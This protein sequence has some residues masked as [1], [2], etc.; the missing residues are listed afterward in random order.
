MDTISTKGSGSREAALEV[1]ERAIA[2]N[3]NLARGYAT[4]KHIPFSRWKHVSLQFLYWGLERSYE[5]GDLDF[6]ADI[7]TVIKSREG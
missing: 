3:S 7:V 4:L 6:V 1:H 2:R 5:N